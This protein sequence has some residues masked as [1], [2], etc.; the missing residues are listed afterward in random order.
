[1]NS[2]KRNICNPTIN[3]QYHLVLRKQTIGKIKELF[4]HW[5]I[6]PKSLSNFI[7]FI[8]LNKNFCY[9]TTSISNQPVNNQINSPINSSKIL[10]KR[11]DKLAKHHTFLSN[12]Q[13][14]PHCLRIVIT[15]EICIKE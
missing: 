15:L 3:K 12:R 8:E 13:K 11:P 1:M 14:F 7:V 5:F 10:Y 2:F 6:Y 4:E 9:K